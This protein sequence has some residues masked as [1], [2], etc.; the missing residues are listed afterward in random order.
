MQEYCESVF[1]RST[2]VDNFITWFKFLKRNIKKY[3][4][5]DY[6]IKSIDTK[7]PYWVE[8]Q[9]IGTSLKEVK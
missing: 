7:N 5:I 1:I 4:V 6:T 9:V 8:L 3:H 2:N